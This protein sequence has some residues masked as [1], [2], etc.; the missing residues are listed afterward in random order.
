M[1]DAE[2][3]EEHDPDEDKPE[4]DKLVT[5]KR[6]GPTKPGRR[7]VSDDSSSDDVIEVTS[8]RVGAPPAKSQEDRDAE[9]EQRRRERKEKEARREARRL[10]RERLSKRKNRNPLPTF[11]NTQGQEAAELKLAYEAYLKDLQK[12][13]RTAGSSF[14]DVI[15][16]EAEETLPDLAT[17]AE[18][19]ASWTQ[20]FSYESHKNRGNRPDYNTVKFWPYNL[21]FPDR[22]KNEAIVAVA[23]GCVV[24]SSRL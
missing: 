2:S 15:D 20:H 18:E 13:K 14:Q 7:H 23:G 12:A 24:G 21:P 5:S 3:I 9:R 10:E 4:V 8:V 6:G 17:I 16:L 19:N 22:R 11:R 1:Q